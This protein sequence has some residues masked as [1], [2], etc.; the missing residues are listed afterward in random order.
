[1]KALP[2]CV[3][4]LSCASMA[5]MNPR[6]YGVDCTGRTDS[7]AALNAMFTQITHR[8]VHFEDCQVRVDHTAII[9]GQT[10]FRLIGDN[11]PGP[12]G[13][14]GSS[15]FGCNGAAGPVLYVNRSM[16]GRIEGLGIYP[17]GPPNICTSN[18]TQSI[19]L[20]NT[21]T[22]GVTGHQFVLEG[23]ALTTSP[24]GGRVSGYKGL[25]ITGPTNNEQISIRDSWIHCQNS[26]LSVGIDL[27]GH[28]SDNDKAY[29]NNI[30]SC[31]HGIKHN[32]GNMR[33][34]GNMF[35]ADGNFS[36]FGPNGAAIY[37]GGQV[38]GPINIEYNEATDGG[39]FINS[40]NDLEGIGGVGSVNMIGN[41]IG[42][43]DM[44]T[45]SYPINLGTTSGYGSSVSGAFVLINN[46]VFITQPGI[47]K[48]V[49]GS[50]AHGDCKWGPLGKL[51]DIANTNH[52]PNNTAG[53]SGCPGGK[54]FQGGHLRLSSPN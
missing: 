42:I 15:I 22:G 29:N 34:S 26:P 24:Q 16:Y 48:T 4:L 25:L 12:G 28:C 18:F 49:I 41:V 14:G 31:F 6:D 33:I 1:M 40:V 9:F 50:S 11:I 23:L 27:E 13:Y 47:T 5:Q 52:W 38:S 32:T 17:I 51:V 3:V 8:T 45:S 46:D 44:S 36:V 10:S 53:W 19:Q 35:S 37:I 7:S 20:D 39:P 21:G 54:D 30:A 43:S 2:I